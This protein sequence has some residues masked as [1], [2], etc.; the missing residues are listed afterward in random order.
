MN[1][2]LNCAITYNRSF[3]YSQLLKTNRAK[4]S[5]LPDPQDLRSRG[6]GQQVF[7]GF[8]LQG[9]LL[10][11]NLLL[12]SCRQVCSYPAWLCSL[13]CLGLLLELPS[14]ALEAA[15][16]AIPALGGVSLQVSLPWSLPGKEALGEGGISRF[17]AQFLHVTHTEMNNFQPS[18]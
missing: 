6:R 15:V 2:L 8:A 12:D 14:H 13:L 7:H 18:S 16:L 1:W 5:R 9:L 3:L 10:G 4:V 11:S 17:R